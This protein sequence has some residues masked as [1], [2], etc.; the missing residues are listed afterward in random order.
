[1]I[2]TLSIAAAA[3]AAAL[4]AP[5]AA[6]E[7]TSSG[8]NGSVT[9]S[10]DADTGYS[11]RREGVNGGSSTA[12]SSCSRGGG[13][14]CDRTYSATN[15]DGET[16]SGERQSHYGPFRGR[17]TGSF[18]GVDGQTYTRSGPTFR[19]NARD[20]GFRRHRPGRW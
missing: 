20:R 10:Y 4:S 8:P 5:A 3:I 19:Y 12:T 13:L 17:S 18:T 6:N 11:V 9:R 7:W 16:I 14:T 2:R 15:R 1:M